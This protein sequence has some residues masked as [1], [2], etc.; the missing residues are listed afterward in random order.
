MTHTNDTL[1]EWHS[2][3]NIYTQWHTHSYKHWHTMIDIHNQWHTKT[4]N[5]P[6]TINMITHDNTQLHTMTY[7]DTHKQVNT[8]IQI[9]DFRFFKYKLSNAT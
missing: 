2:H 9:L 7:N 5:D 4:H 3:N 1:I 8:S 6:H